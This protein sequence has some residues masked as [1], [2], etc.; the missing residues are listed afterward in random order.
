[1]GRTWPKILLICAVALGACAV[2][3]LII[4]A[5]TG[6]DG[7]DGSE[8]TR[9]A[10]RQPT[11]APPDRLGPAPASVPSVREWDPV[12]GPGWQP[13]DD[14]RVVAP[15]NSPLADEARLL[16]RELDLAYASGTAGPSDVLLALDPDGGIPREGYELRSRDGLVRITGSTDAGVFYGTRTL[17]Q[18][19]RDEGRMADGT[20]RDEPARA[21]RGFML[22]IAR[23]HY[24]AEWIKDRVREMGD[25]KLNQLQLHLSDDQAFRIESDR[26][27]EIVSDPH[28]TKAQVRE[29]ID[30]AASRHITVIPEI[31]SPGHLGAV[32]E[33]EPGFQLRDA[34]G[35]PVPGAIDISDRAAGRYVD[36][37]LDEY[38]D[39]FP[40]PWFHLGG[41]EYAAL[42]EADPEAAFPGLASAARSRFGPGADVEDLATAWLNAR[43][44]TVRAHDKTAQ[45]WNDGMH[46]GG[47]VQPSRPRE[48]TYWTG[49][50]IGARPPA[51][52][53]RED[54][55]VVNMND[56]YLYYVLG[57][58]NEFT[59]P[60]GE[61][62][63]EEWTPAVVRGTDPLPDALSGPDRILGGRFAVWG[64]IADAQTTAQVADGIRL[65]L[66]ATAQ[67]L[68]NPTRPDLTWQQF[69]SLVDR[70][71]ARP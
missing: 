13:T 15:E 52:Y 58:P 32:L 2:A 28:L 54:W 36:D 49:K 50:E 53:L 24:S 11:T 62:I 30:L 71:D 31:D 44:K 20:I 60:T 19:V 38:A 23:K 16:A 47:A 34:A 8:E 63:Y 5:V 25:L 41:D 65:P 67:K 55:E 43:A 7:G 10:T 14:S 48:V 9:P 21:Q 70:V 57:E 64:D 40:G 27:P 42:F 59:Y 45:V 22:D 46:E 35:E 39:L 12:R 68:W 56:E 51:D 18:T 69:T 33:A 29:I 66:A 1:M 17:L 6:D 3:A 4:L 61:R 37:L 26:H